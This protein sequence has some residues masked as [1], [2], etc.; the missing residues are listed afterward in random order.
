MQLH[1]DTFGLPCIGVTRCLATVENLR[2]GNASHYSI[3][4]HT[5]YV[6]WLPWDHLFDPIEIVSWMN[7]EKILL[8][9]SDICFCST[10]Q[11][12]VTAAPLSRTLSTR[13]FW[14]VLFAF[15]PGAGQVGF[16]WE[17]SCMDAE[18]VRDIFLEM[19]ILSSDLVNWLIWWLSIEMTCARSR[20]W[21]LLDR[22]HKIW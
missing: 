16:V 17:S 12:T 20:V 2:R 19:K 15:T 14:R 18:P 3:K 6:E 1:C 21:T 9:M 10:S 7:E 13:H 4:F 5:D 22:G 8:M 11:Q